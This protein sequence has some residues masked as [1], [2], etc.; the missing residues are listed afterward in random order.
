LEEKIAIIILAAGAS[1]R[2]NKPKQLLKFRGKSLI[3]HAVDTAFETNLGPV[4][5][6]LGKSAEEIT[7][8]L[9]DYEGKITISINPDWN[10]GISSSIKKGLEQV[11]TKYN[12]IYG[13][14]VAL[15]DQPLITVAHF[16]NMV[17][18]HFTFGKNIIASGYG[19]SFGAPTFFHKSIF[20]YIE[21]LD[22]DDGAKSIISKLKRDVHIIPLTDAE[23]DIDTEEDYKNLL[24]RA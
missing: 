8:R 4:F 16:V 6:V 9:Q 23:L 24:N 12:D 21:K 11:E 2:F 13:V 5:V 19:G 17:K 3:E 18:S 14:I 7:N 22:G 10:D 15:A 20:N 1:S